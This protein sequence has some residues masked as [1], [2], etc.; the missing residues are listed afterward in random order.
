M[1]PLPDVSA[2]RQRGGESFTPDSR[3]RF[4]SSMLRPFA[5]ILVLG[6]VGK[7]GVTVTLLVS[8]FAVG[9]LLPALMCQHRCNPHGFG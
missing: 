1:L 8:W 9:V 3:K 5:Q 6:C 2:H 4:Q 7:L